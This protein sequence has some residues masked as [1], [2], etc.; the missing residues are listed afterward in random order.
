MSNRPNSYD[1]FFK[2]PFH[3]DGGYGYAI[4][5]KDSWEARDKIVD[6]L[7]FEDC[8][9]DFMHRLKR[10]LRQNMKECWVRFQGYVD[11]DGEFHNGW[12]ITSEW[13]GGRKGWRL[14]WTSDYNQHYVTYGH[15]YE[16]KADE[17]G[18]RVNYSYNNW[19]CDVCNYIDVLRDEAKG[20]VTI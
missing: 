5:A 12:V 19:N 6:Y 15:R 11:D 16:P 20:E 9:V 1:N 3:Y 7:S 14:V 17:D 4:K 2:E 10:E 8:G 18:H 13:M